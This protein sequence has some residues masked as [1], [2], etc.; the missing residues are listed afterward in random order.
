MTQWDDPVALSLAAQRVTLADLIPPHLPPNPEAG[1]VADFRAIRRKGL[2]P[3]S[4]EQFDRIDRMIRDVPGGETF[5]Y[6]RVNGPSVALNPHL[7]DVYGIVR[8][9]GLSMLED[10]DYRRPR[11]R[12]KTVKPFE[13]I[14][15]GTRSAYVGGRT[16]KGCHCDA[17]RQA[18]REYFA[19]YRSKSS[20]NRPSAPL[21]SPAPAGATRARADGSPDDA[22][23]GR[24]RKRGR[25]PGGVA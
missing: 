8:D 4:D 2:R 13:T 12:T 7:S 6:R 14:I 5:G 10:P 17:C 19:T 21:P 24:S 22:G 1:R 23:R 9:G 15:H 20:A 3:M 18:N 11:A 25:S 16:T